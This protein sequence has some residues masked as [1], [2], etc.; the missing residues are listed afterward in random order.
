MAT[1][2]T[3]TNVLA[4][5]LARA[6]MILRQKSSLPRLINSNFSNEAAQKGSTVNIP[7][8]ESDATV[9]DV[10]PSNTEPALVGDTPGL[11]QITMDQWKSVRFHLTDKEIVEV[12]TNVQFIPQQLERAI[13]A[14]AK[15][16]NQYLFSFYTGIYGFVGTPGET[17][18]SGD[19]GTDPATMSRMLL[20]IQKAPDNGMRVGVLDPIG[21]ASA[22]SLPA[23]QGADKSGNE[24]VITEGMIGRKFGSTW[25]WDHDVPYHVA[26]TWTQCQVTQANAVGSG[27]TQTISVT[28]GAGGALD[29]NIGDIIEIAGHQYTYTVTAGPGDGTTAAIGASTA[30][31]ITIAPI[32]RAATVGGEEITVKSSHRVNIHMHKEAIG[33]AWRPLLAA[34]RQFAIDT[35]MMSMADP[36]TGLVLR[37]EVKRVHKAVVWE[38]DALYGAQLVR[39]QY[40][41][42]IAG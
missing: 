2:N 6:L 38:L 29:L 17:P 40:A 25:I 16:V 28:T 19:Q 12:Q 7:T 21:E 26:G 41:V 8:Y 9:N 30:G 33:L 18:F 24:N 35:Q 14:L 5:I 31:N 27:R 36:L 23:F 4:K 22:L 20:N 13:E 15:T 42:R 32:L 1:T 34:T 37:L 11:V 10:T 3:L 39:P